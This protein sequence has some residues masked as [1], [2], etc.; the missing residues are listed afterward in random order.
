M[1][2]K[3]FTLIELMIVIAIISFLAMIGIPNY[4]RFVAKSKRTEVYLNLGALYVAEKAHW[5]EHGTYSDKL[6]GTDGI[7]WTPEG[8]FL[9]T[10]GFAG[11][12]DLNCHQGKLAGPISALNGIT[13]ANREGFVVGAVADIDGDGVLDIITMNDKHII[14]IVQDDLN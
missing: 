1:H 14:K 13:H 12:P 6:T 5:A 3:G 7:G 4:M 10:Y 8:D 11:T 2:G 9:Y